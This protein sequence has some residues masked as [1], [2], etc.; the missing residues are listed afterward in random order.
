MTKQQLLSLLEATAASA[1]TLRHVDH[2]WKV[3]SESFPQLDNIFLQ[4]CHAVGCHPESAKSQVR[5][6]LNVRARNMFVYYLRETFKSV[7]PLT[8]IGAYLGGRDHTTIMNSR[9]VFDNLLTTGDS[10][11][12][13]DWNNLTRVMAGLDPTRMGPELTPRPRRRYTRMYY[14]RQTDR[15]YVS[16]KLLRSFYGMGKHAYINPYRFTKKMVS[17][18]VLPE[19]DVVA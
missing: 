19:L 2:V 3:G 4:C 6:R 14:E 5:T 17:M 16:A 9:R 10:V 12:L 1:E 8:E 7:Y 15:Y 11:T 13:L 18:D